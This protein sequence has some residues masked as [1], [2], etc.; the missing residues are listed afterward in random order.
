MDKIRV[1]LIFAV[2]FL[3]VCGSQETTGATKEMLKEVSIGTPRDVINSMTW[4][5][6][7]KGY[8]EEEGLNITLQSYPSGK[9]ALAGMLDDKVQIA[10]SAE[11]PIMSNLFKK[12]DFSIFCT[13]GISGNEVKIVA[14]RDAGISNPSDIKGKRIATQ[15]NSA[16]HFFLYRFLIYNGITE[17]ELNIS[18]LHPV[19]LVPALVNGDIDAFSMRE[20]FI[21]RARDNFGDNIIIFEQPGIYTKTFN[22]IA[23]D[24]FIHDN[25]ETIRKMLKAFIKAEHFMKQNRKESIEII[26]KQ[27]GLNKEQLK[28]EWNDYIF[29]LS[30]NQSLLITLE[31]EARWAIKTGLV[32]K[33]QIPNYLI[34]IYLNAL[35]E[36][37]PQALTIIH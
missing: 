12:K 11:V 3:W 6:K 9:L 22:L 36:V 37:K 15:K 31:S 18:Y 35:N 34:S 4:I 27:H 10:T 8:F 32:N 17:S 20:P 2:F 26:A 19:D 1:S 24:K 25:P 23:H 21:Q 30:L 13:I 16:V 28:N 29:E 33:R 14:R 7:E 5:A